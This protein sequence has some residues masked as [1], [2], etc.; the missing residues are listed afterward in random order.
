MQERLYTCAHYTQSIFFFS[1]E[2]RQQP[3]HVGGFVLFEIP[4]NASP[5]FRS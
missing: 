3:M 1:L 5:T 2:K 4:E